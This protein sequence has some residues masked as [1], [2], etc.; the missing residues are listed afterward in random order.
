[1]NP[2]VS[3][4][5]KAEKD[6]T[7]DFPIDKVKIA[8]MDMFKLFPNKYLL[9]KNDINE[10]FNTYHFAISNVVN[11]GIVDMTLEKVDENKTKIKLTVTNPYGST[12]SNSILAG[13][14]SDYL[15]VLGKVLSGENIE[16][17]KETVKNSGCLIVI[18]FGI[19]SFGLMSFF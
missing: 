5:Q 17:I 13:V 2:A 16:D 10:I 18:L 12:S 6:L 15:L 1:M 8:V 9:R 7:I 11:P 3:S 19:V 4:L 14:A